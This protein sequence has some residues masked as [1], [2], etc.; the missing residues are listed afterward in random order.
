MHFFTI[1]SMEQN[2]HYILKLIAQ[3]IRRARQDLGISQEKLAEL[4]DVHRTYIGM[5]ERAEKNVTILSLNKIAQ[6]LN[7]KMEYFFAKEKKD[8]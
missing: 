3:N 5:L 1:V 7:K 4:A 6:A 2:D 8:D